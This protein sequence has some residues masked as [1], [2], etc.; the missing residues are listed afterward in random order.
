M[1]FAEQP[2]AAKWNI[3]GTNDAHFYSFLGDNLTWTAWV[4]TWG[5]L[6]L[7]A[8]TVVAK[9]ARVG[10]I[11]LFKL[12]IT[13]GAGFSIGGS[14]SFS[15]PVTSVAVTGVGENMSL[16]KLRDTSTTT[17]YVGHLNHDSTTTAILKWPSVA[18][19]ALVDANLSSTSPFTW[20][21]TD[22]IF[23]SGFYEAA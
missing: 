18:G 7:G 14:V 19:S 23:A 4:P 17:S 9:Y 5:N 1:A 12:A 3:L 22:L 13:M 21:T 2:S 15:L 16:V 11:I 20:A 6:T 10:N 8:S